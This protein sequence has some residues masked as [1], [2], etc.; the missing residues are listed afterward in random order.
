MSGSMSSSI[1]RSLCYVKKLDEVSAKMT[2]IFRNLVYGNSYRARKLQPCL[3]NLLTFLRD[4]VMMSYKWLAHD[5]LSSRPKVRYYLADCLLCRPG[6]CA[7]LG[8]ELRDT[9]KG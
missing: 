1:L 6:M 2:A 3:P 7:I 8:L 4:T 5:L 9:T